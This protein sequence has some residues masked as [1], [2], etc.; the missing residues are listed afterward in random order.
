VEPFHNGEAI[1]DILIRAMTVFEGLDLRDVP[2]GQYIFSGL[3]LRIAADGAPARDTHPDS[4]G[5]MSEEIVNWSGSLRFTPAAIVTPA[6]RKN[7][8]AL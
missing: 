2:A 7:S 1:H 6:M 3:P 8:A 4:G 5:T